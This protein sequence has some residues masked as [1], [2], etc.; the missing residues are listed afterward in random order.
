MIW[1]K[2]VGA[3][4]A[5]ARPGDGG[6]IAKRKELLIELTERRFDDFGA[7]SE[8]SSSL[9]VSSPSLSVNS[10]SVRYRFTVTTSEAQKNN[11]LL[12]SLRLPEHLVA[13]S[14]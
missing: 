11:R 4:V 8:A 3:G 5:G 6:G 2:R 9:F 13:S 14:S 1:G 10:A 12:S 7:V